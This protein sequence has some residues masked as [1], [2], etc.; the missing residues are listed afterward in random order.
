MT[1][2]IVEFNGITALD[3][4]PQMVIHGALDAGLTHVVIIGFDANGDEYFASSM[5]DAGDVNWH[6]ERAKWNLM[7]KVDE[8][9]GA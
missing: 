8:L 6:L 5:A 1:A 3:I 2:E 9:T 7:R 4:N